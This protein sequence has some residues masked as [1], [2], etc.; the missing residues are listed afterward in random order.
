MY[1]ASRA[2]AGK[3]LA[4]L[5]EDYKNEKCTV[6]GLSDGAVV[7]GAQIASYLRCPLT[8]LLAEKI[9]A[10][11]EPE[12]VSAIDQYGV[13]T[14]NTAYSTG[15]LE[16]FNMEYHQIFEQDK[17]DKLNKMHRLLGKNSLIRKDLLRKRT[18]I[19]VSDGLKSGFSLDAAVSY[20]KTTKINHLLVATPLASVGAVDRM[21]IVGDKIFCLMVVENYLGINHYYVD[22]TI[23]PHEVI[24]ETVQNIV[25]NW[26]IDP[27]TKKG[28]I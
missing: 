11:G 28:K 26:K 4:K 1:F 20:L 6:V 22:N 15:Q 21:H 5:L 27:K 8:M 25:S 3:Q 14:E 17:L 12:A 7:V 9:K 18:V 13:T 2:E 23:P 16:E 24:V 10:P 19:L